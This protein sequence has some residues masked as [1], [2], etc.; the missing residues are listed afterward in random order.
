MKRITAILASAV[1]M[2]TACAEFVRFASE[3]LQ[4]LMRDA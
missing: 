1:L 2:L 3:T 4:E